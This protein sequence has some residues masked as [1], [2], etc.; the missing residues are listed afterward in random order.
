MSCGVFWEYIGNIHTC[1]RKFTMAVK[2]HYLDRT[3]MKCKE[4]IV[5][6]YFSIKIEWVQWLTNVT[7]SWSERRC[8]MLYREVDKYLLHDM[9]IISN[10]F[11]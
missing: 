2:L 11:E 3:A 5:N 8:N 1:E 7:M 6:S 4:G 10:D 9:K